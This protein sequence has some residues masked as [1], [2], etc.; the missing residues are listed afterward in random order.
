MPSVPS[1]ALCPLYG[2]P[3]P[4]P[5]S[6]CPS[7]ALNP[8]PP[9]RHLLPL[10]P[11]SPLRPSVTSAACV[12]YGPSSL[13]SMVLCILTGHMPPSTLYSALPPNDPLHALCPLYGP[14]SPFTA[15]CLLYGPL[16]PLWLSVH[17][18]ALCP[19][20][21]PLSLLR[22]YVPLRPSVPS[23]ALCPLYGSLYVLQPFN[24]L[25]PSPPP[26]MAL[27]HLYGPLSPIGALSHLCGPV[28]SK[29]VCPFNRC[30]VSLTVSRNGDV[31]SLFCE[32]CSAE[33][34]HFA[35]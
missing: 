23:T 6:L 22:I 19:L 10:Q 9:P 25:S 4:P 27:Y 2:P 11:V 3:P 14:M 8:A 32:T 33:T 13:C 24:P 21:D 20:Y 18:M 5:T 17:S 7:I 31:A 1:T 12:L 29:A 30:V 28:L 34:P 15:L 16:S 26:R 35:K